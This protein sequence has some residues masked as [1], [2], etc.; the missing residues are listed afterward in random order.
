MNK[1][2]VIEQYKEIA[3]TYSSFE[4]CY[5]LMTETSNVEVCKFCLDYDGVWKRLELKWMLEFF[6][7][8]EDYEKCNILK[9]FMDESY[10]ADESKQNEL[11][12]KLDEYVSHINGSK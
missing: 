5:K 11:N 12:S 6:Q 10:I 7:N 4:D 3:K 2:N 9:K 8:K 1:E